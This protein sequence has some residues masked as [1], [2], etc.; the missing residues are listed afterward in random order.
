LLSGCAAVELTNASKQ[1]HGGSFPGTALQLELDLR[2][3]ES[4]SARLA[5]FRNEGIEAARGF[6]KSD[7]ITASLA[8]TTLSRN[9]A[10]SE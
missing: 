9:F 6:F 10:H 4:L 2:N 7:Q 1:F 8:S 3:A 5:K